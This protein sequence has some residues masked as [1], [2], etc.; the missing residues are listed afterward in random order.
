MYLRMG[1]T[2]GSESGHEEMLDVF[3]MG[4]RVGMVISAS[5]APKDPNRGTCRTTEAL[6]Q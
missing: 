5:D 6:S 4:K 1:V 2:S 3:S